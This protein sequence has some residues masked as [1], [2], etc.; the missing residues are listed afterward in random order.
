M[1]DANSLTIS[2]PTQTAVTTLKICRIQADGKDAIW[3]SNEEAETPF[4]PS[5][6]NEAKAN[7]QSLDIRCIGDYLS[8]FSQ[9]DCWAVEYISVNSLRLFGKQLHC[10]TVKEMYKPCIKK[11]AS[12]DPL[13]RAKITLEGSHRTRYWTLDKEARSEPDCWQGTL[14]KTRIR[15]SYLY[16]TESAFGLALDCT[17]VQVCKE[18]T[19]VP[20]VC[21]F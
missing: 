10:N 17:D 15:I 1:L 21:P 4:T 20:D 13:L 18:F 19:P 12:F 16:V 9:L 8:F 2:D 7:K 3:S 14:F 11:I 6:F 5:S